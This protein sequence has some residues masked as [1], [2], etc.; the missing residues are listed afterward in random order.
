M[1]VKCFATNNLV[2][3][4]DDYVKFMK[5]RN[6]Y[7]KENFENGTDIL[8]CKRG[9]IDEVF[10]ISVKK[11]GKTKYNAE[12]VRLI[13]SIKKWH[14]IMIAYN[15][16]CKY[17]AKFY[18]D[19]DH[20]RIQHKTFVDIPE[21][22]LE[23]FKHKFEWKVS[24]AECKY[25]S[26]AKKDHLMDPCRL[27]A[28]YW[29]Y[30]EIVND[31][32]TQRYFPNIATCERAVKVFGYKKGDNPFKMNGKFLKCAVCN[33]E[34]KG[35]M[36]KLVEACDEKTKAKVAD[37]SEMLI[38]D[39]EFSYRTY[40]AL[41]RHE[42]NTF[43]DLINKT[44]S[45]LMKIRN[46]GF[47]SLREVVAKLKEYGYSYPKDDEGSLLWIQLPV[48]DN[49]EKDSVIDIAEQAAKE[50]EE[51]KPGITEQLQDKYNTLCDSHEKLSGKYEVLL[52]T[53]QEQAD[54]Y[55]KLLREKLEL[56]N[57]NSR[58][59]DQLNNLREENAGIKAKLEKESSS[60]D[61]V[62]ILAHVVDIMKKHNITKLETGIGGYSIDIL[63]K[64]VIT[65]RS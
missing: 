19:R 14:S 22:V 13:K 34:A 4:H 8:I 27:L 41:K 7:E 39:M 35:S 53:A 24:K 17:Y 51:E 32:K 6:N 40:N 48:S 38:E 1:A 36:D 47:V 64:F 20:S 49:K 11:L 9:M 18:I 29:T 57:F 65:G 16:W 55:D 21:D 58:L 28:I 15:M 50:V 60:T 2:K 45:D 10:D 56:E 62:A 63:Q 30:L 42:I 44:I 59:R 31:T 54:N 37:I 33:T 12:L 61:I 3:E 52:K 46:F 23:K 25:Y 43:G 26:N 5:F